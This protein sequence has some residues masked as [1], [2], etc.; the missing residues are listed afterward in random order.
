M[1]FE[2]QKAPICHIEKLVLI[3]WMVERRLLALQ[4]SEC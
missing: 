3:N 2:N 4:T 1:G